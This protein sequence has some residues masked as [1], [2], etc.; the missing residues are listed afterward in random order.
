MQRVQA[1]GLL[2]V[3]LDEIEG[4]QVSGLVN[5]ARS[6]VGSQIG[7]LNIADTCTGVF[8]LASSAL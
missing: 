4:A 3:C 6:V 7:F 2:N 1:A 8:P 5:V